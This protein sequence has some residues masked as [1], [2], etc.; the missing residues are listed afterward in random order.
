MREWLSANRRS[1][2]DLSIW[3][4]KKLRRARS[5]V[6]GRRI[7]RSIGFG[8]LKYLRRRRIKHGA[9]AARQSNRAAWRKH[10]IGGRAGG[11]TQV[12]W[13]QRMPRAG[14]EEGRS[15]GGA[16]AWHAVVIFAHHRGDGVFSIAST[17]LPASAKEEKK[18]RRR[19][20]KRKK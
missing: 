18:E 20:K 16:A 12:V 6:A 4:E 17:R 11:K 9:A 10:G 13:R 1:P 5:M 19:R 2:V 3:K 15:G 14:N 7:R 8:A